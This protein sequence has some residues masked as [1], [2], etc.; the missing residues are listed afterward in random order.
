MQ[1]SRIPISRTSKGNENWFKKSRVQEIAKV[2]SDYVEMRSIALTGAVVHIIIE[3]RPLCC[4]SRSYLQIKR[5]LV[6]E[7]TNCTR[8]EECVSM[9]Y[10][11]RCHLE[12]FEFKRNR[13]PSRGASIS[14][15]WPW[16][17]T[18]SWVDLLIERLPS[19][20]S[21]AH[22]WNIQAYNAWISHSFIL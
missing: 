9:Y 22:S 1:W 3:V 12:S 21:Q 20:V 18:L 16:K 6:K 19:E 7:E 11:F 10:T 14:H 15:T 13:S 2:A 5:T 4:K 17:A 8:Y